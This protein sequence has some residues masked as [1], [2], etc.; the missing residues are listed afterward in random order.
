M[1]RLSIVLMV[2]W[3]GLILY[4]C[5]DGLG[6]FD[7]TF[8]EPTSVGGRVGFTVGLTFNMILWGIPMMV[9]GIIALLTRPR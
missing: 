7:G 5:F 3:T 6:V 1:Y 2:V 8:S 9:L 4:S